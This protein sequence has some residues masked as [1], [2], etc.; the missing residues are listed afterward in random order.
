MK[1]RLATSADIPAIVTL[2]RQSDGAAHWSDENYNTIFNA[3]DP[4]RLIVVMETGG[5][6]AA[7]VVV[8]IV[9]SEW[10]V[11]NIVVDSALRRQGIGSTLIRD[12]QDRARA[13]H[14]E[15]LLLE[16]RESNSAARSLYEKAG[17]IQ[18]GHR[19]RYYQNPE[20]NAICYCFEVASGE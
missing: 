20:E 9:G 7:F 17:F 19:S 14:A 10:E 13:E 11:E 12:L 15:L 8:R 18:W 4:R 2:E 1:L 3:S 5:A 6:A 16:V